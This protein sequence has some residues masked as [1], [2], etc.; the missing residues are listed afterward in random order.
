M[1]P[2]HLICIAL[3][4]SIIFSLLSRPQTYDYSVCN[5]GP[6]KFICAIIYSKQQGAPPF[7]LYVVSACC[8][9]AVSKYSI[10]WT[11][12]ITRLI[13]RIQLMLY[14][15][16]LP[17][18]CLARCFCHVWFEFSVP[19][20]VFFSIGLLRGGTVPGTKMNVSL[21]YVKAFHKFTRDHI[22]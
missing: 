6:R 1:L 19:I 9:N 16:R 11:M 8:V 12:P 18:G 10:G 22:H 21:S 5:F 3:K 4:S 13:A 7:G 17:D 2:V 14:S 15:V 20:G